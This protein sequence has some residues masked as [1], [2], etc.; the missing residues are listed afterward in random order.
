MAEAWKSTIIEYGPSDWQIVQRDARGFGTITF[1][2]KRLG[3]EKGAAEVRLVSE[4]TGAPPSRALDWHPVPT[5]ADGTWSAELREVPA[6]GLYR[7]ETR[8]RL[9][10]Y[11]PGEA[12]VRGDTSHFLGVGD[13]WVIAGQSNSAGRPLGPIHDP[14]ELG[15]HL[16][17]NSEQWALAAHP[18]ND[19]TDTKHP[20]NQDKYPGHSPYLQ[21][22]RLLKRALNIPIGLVQT[23][24]GASP[25]LRW[26]PAE[27]GEADLFDNMVHCVERAGGNT[28]GILWYQG[29]QD[30]V[31]SCETNDCST[32]GERFSRAVAVWREALNEPDLPVITVQL[33]RW[34]LEATEAQERGWSQVREAQRQAAR[35][36]EGVA[37]VPSLDAPLFDKI[38]TSPAGNMMLGER[39]A[40]AALGMVYGQP[41]DY[42]APDLHVARLVDDGAVIELV[43][44]HVSGRM[45]P[46]DRAANPFRVEDEAGEVPV[47]EVV[48]PLDMR[49]RLVLG[50]P[51]S[52]HAVVHGGFGANPEAVPLDKE[53][54][55]PMLAFYGVAVE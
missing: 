2:G 29:E 46:I 20:V 44:E 22:G 52:G 50:R 41:V 18:L 23:A 25:L 19:S 12:D 17:G 45:E 34:Y 49:V 10:E 3:D 15:V 35:K 33:N 11:P 37:V 43:F 42:L 39:M 21:F 8:F 7:L 30:A 31:D 28:R 26:N 5:S 48:Y 54:L 32:Y 13:V 53:R 14:P 36:I 9:G 24:L 6:G 1:G 47:E 51:V 40:R 55:A 38:H 4:E 27:R 16:F